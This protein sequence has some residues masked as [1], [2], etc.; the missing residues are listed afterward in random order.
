MVHTHGVHT[1]RAHTYA[2]TTHTRTYTRTHGTRIRAHGTRNAHTRTHIRMHSHIRVKAA[3]IVKICK[4]ILLYKVKNKYRVFLLKSIYL[5]GKVKENTIPLH[6]QNKMT[7]KKNGRT[8]SWCHVTPTKNRGR[9]STDT[10][11]TKIKK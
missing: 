3:A 10:Q 5:F 8:E 4:I 6:C 9:M 7:T 11:R 2:H 1:R